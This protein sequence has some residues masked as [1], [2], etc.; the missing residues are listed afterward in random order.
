MFLKEGMLLNRACVRQEAV[1][2]AGKARSRTDAYAS[3]ALDFNQ[4]LGLTHH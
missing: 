1:A 4:C 3:P 2:V